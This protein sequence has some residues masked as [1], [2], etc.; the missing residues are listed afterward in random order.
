MLQS[1]GKALG[2]PTEAYY[3]LGWARCSSSLLDVPEQLGL[4][5]PEGAALAGSRRCPTQSPYGQ[6]QDKGM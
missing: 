2:I 6:S 1:S 3:G 5:V 4:V